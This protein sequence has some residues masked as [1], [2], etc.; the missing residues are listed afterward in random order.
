MIWHY[1]NAGGLLLVA[2]A[3]YSMLLSPSLLPFFRSSSHPRA[4]F[5]ASTHTF[6]G[7]WGGARSRAPLFT[8]PL[9][10]TA[11]S[12]SSPNCTLPPSPRRPSHPPPPPELWGSIHEEACKGSADATRLST[13]FERGPSSSRWTSIRDCWPLRTHHR[14]SF[15]SKI[16][17][18]FTHARINNSLLLACSLQLQT[19]FNFLAIFVTFS[20]LSLF[21]IM[22]YKIIKKNYKISLLKKM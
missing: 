21:L 18:P 3:P 19:Y 1:H 7:W 22:I 17:F 6:L 12:P 5:C 8:T 9:P 20:L 15:H 16:V 11:A 14:S 4:V 2:S 13:F 10:P